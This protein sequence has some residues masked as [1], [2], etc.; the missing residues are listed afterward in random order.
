MNNTE[1]ERAYV[2]TS[3]SIHYTKLYDI[4]ADLHACPF[5]DLDADRPLELGIS[6]Q[7]FPSPVLNQ[8]RP[9]LL[10]GPAKGV[11][12]PLQSYNFV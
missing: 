11:V 8:E 12:A 3:Y 2:I 1:S 7:D 9:V 4:V 10:P 5:V 6:D